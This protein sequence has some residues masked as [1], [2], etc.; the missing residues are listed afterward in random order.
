[1]TT[2]A[3]VWCDR[4]AV[5]RGL[6]RRCYARYRRGISPIAP[7]RGYAVAEDKQRLRVEIT[8]RRESGERVADI[9]AAVGVGVS[10]VG[11]WLREWGV[12]AGPRKSERAAN[13]W[14]PWSQEDIEFAVSRTDLTVADRAAKLGRSAT[15]VIECIRKHS[16]R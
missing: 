11:R 8:R 12:Q 15:S 16:R 4:P 6:C 9:A 1:M 2:C 13:L 10:P 14:R 5:L 7:G 3:V